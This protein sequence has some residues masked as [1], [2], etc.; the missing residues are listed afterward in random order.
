MIVHGECQ[1]PLKDSLV[2]FFCKLGTPSEVP[3]FARLWAV[4]NLCSVLC[5]DYVVLYNLDSGIVS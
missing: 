3:K 5:A 1:L 4:Y 2:L